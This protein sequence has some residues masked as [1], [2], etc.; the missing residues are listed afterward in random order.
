VSLDFPDGFMWGASTAAHQIEGYQRNNWSPEW[1]QSQSERLAAEAE[2]R[3]SGTVPGYDSIRA[4]AEQSA[5]YISGAGADHYNRYAE[6]IEL[7]AE[8]LNLNAL[9]V[10]VEWARIEPEPGQFDQD[11]LAHYRD[12]VA[13]MRK[14]SIEPHVVLHHFTNPRWFDEIGWHDKRAPE[15]FVRFAREVQSAL[16]DVRYW[17]TINEPGS[18][19]IMRY[20]GARGGWP[21]WP[22]SE[23]NFWRGHQCINNFIKA[24]RAVYEDFKARDNDLQIS[25][26][27]MELVYEN[28]AGLLGGLYKRVLDYYPNHYIWSRIN[29][30]QDF[31]GLQ[32]YL[33]MDIRRNS[34]NPATWVQHVVDGEHSDMGWGIRP[35]L[36]GKVTADVYRRYRKP[37]IINEHG[38][39]DAQD[40]HRKRFL[41]DSLKSLRLAIDQGADVRGY[42]HWSLLDNY[43]WSEGWWPKFGLVAVDRTSPEF[44]RSVKDSARYYARIVATNTVQPLD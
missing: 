11:A 26:T 16:P 39:A 19:L 30:H 36:L 28:H 29:N 6:D 20:G 42:L 1:E 21:S 18:Y 43:E 22:K 17:L 40:Q 15:L 5:N 31:I 4:E 33:Q 13:E 2:Q 34:F 7:A 35:E 14:H 44:T 8:Q 24:H 27:Q 3:L 9:R 10:S 38:I 23:D 25:L 32:H 12:V 37:I 41:H